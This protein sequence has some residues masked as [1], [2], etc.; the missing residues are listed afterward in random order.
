MIDKAAI[1]YLASS[2][3]APICIS[4]RGTIHA[5]GKITDAVAARWWI[6]A[7]MAVPVARAARTAGDNPDVS[8]ATAALHRAAA[9]LRVAL[10]AD[11]IAVERARNAA[12]RL[13]AYLSGRGVLRDFNAAFKQRREAAAMQGKGFM[14]YWAA[15]TRLRKALIPMLAGAHTASPQSLFAQIFGRS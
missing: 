14:S 3:A 4:E 9:S 13:D 2:G 11:N 12:M 8:V 15:E 6:D 1:N 5:G 10:T 7:R